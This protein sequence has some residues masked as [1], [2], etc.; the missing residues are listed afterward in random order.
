MEKPLWEFIDDK[1]TFRSDSADKVNTLYFPL[2]NDSPFM[3]SITPDLHGDIKTNNNSFLMQPVS[4]IDLNNLK[5]SRN[6]W[7]YL[8]PKKSWSCTGVSKDLQTIKGDR[9]T[10]EAGLLWQKITRQNNSVGLKSTITSFVPSSGEPIE[11][12]RV[13]ITNVSKKPIKFTP[14]AAIP[15]YCRSANN[16]RDHRHVTSL[17][18]RTEIDKYGVIVTPTLLFDESGHHKNTTSY[19]VLGIDGKSAGPEYIYP[20]QEDFCGDEGDLEAPIAVLANRLPNKH[21]FYQ[22]KEPMAGLKFRP[23]TLSPG[24]S[25]SFIVVMGITQQ[26]TK[27]KSLFHK[28][29]TLKKIEQSL[30]TTKAYWEKKSAEISIHTADTTFDN[31]FRWVSIQPALR[32]VFGCSFLPDFDYGRGGR[33][34][35]DLW[36]DCLSLILT[37]PNKTR[38]LLINNF[39]GVRIDG[40]NATIIGQRPGEFIADRNNISRVWMDHGI[41][42]LLTTLLYIHQTGDLKLLLEKTAYFRDRQISRSRQI[43]QN[44]RPQ[45]ENQLKTKGNTIYKGT[46]LE[47]ILLQHLVQFFNVGPHNHIRLE[48]ADWNDGLDMA[49]RNGESVAF[50]CMYGANLRNICGLLEKMP[51]KKIALLKEVA[52]LLDSLSPNTCNYNSVSAKL[53]RLEKYYR[54]ANYAVSGKTALIDKEKIIRDLTRKAN[55]IE[56]HVQKTE[57][58]KEG[59]FNGYYNNDKKRVEGKIAGNTRMTLTGQ[60][61][62]LMSGIATDKQVL[63]LFRNVKKYLQDKSLG[64]FRLNSDFKSE[65]YNLGRAFSFIYGDKENGAFF[66]HMA[67]MFAYGLYKQG[68]AEEGFEVLNSIYRM[69]ANTG[70]GK[71][72]PGLPEYF[73]AQGRGMYSYLTGSASWFILTMLTQ[74]FGIRGEYGD[75]TLEPKLT[76]SQFKGSKSIAVRTCFAA[77]KFLIRFSNPH[78]KGFEEYAIKRLTINNRKLNKLTNQKSQIIPRS[79]LLTLSRS[80]LN[81]IEVILD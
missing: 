44:W 79:M 72:Y 35:R 51:A 62:P 40:S 18:M 48:G 63:I 53:A 54:L 20:S 6:F 23:Q 73:N 39:A 15:L 55:W 14:T 67:V 43:D 37:E 10:L 12:M 1:G 65:Q 29:N 69:S 31:W 47:H 42:P 34:W 58:L 61:F 60:T 19:F 64:G 71:I 21:L 36:Q 32:K 13:D 50:T 68:F 27:I 38:S 57:W 46:V 2:C 5:S 74:A 52:I 56:S 25:C 77:R 24:K 41:W 76:K 4:R 3:S 59:F 66:S 17:L 49:T 26:K 33:G 80:R 81:I 8:S 70:A 78:Q 11:I 75:L 7:I 9:F 45:Y 28:F 16:L 22:G 30:Q